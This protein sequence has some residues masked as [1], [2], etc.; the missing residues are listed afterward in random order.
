M[1]YCLLHFTIITCEYSPFKAK[2]EGDAFM[3]K[4]ISSFVNIQTLVEAVLNFHNF[5]SRHEENSASH[6][7]HDISISP[8]VAF[9]TY[10]PN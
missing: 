1:H 7:I 3:R 4:H 6:Y 9:Y 5:C 2:A 10:L 8:R